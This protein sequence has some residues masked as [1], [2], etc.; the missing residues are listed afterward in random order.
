VGEPEMEPV[1]VSKT[2][3]SGGGEL[4]V[5]EVAGPPVLVGAMGFDVDPLVK[6]KTD[7]V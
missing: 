1:D 4:T 6:V 5:Q 3:P 7:G 2:R